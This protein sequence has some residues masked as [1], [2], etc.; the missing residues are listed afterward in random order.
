MHEFAE[1][2]L[3][4]EADALFGELK[5]VDPL[6]AQKYDD[7]NPR[8]VDRAL[9]FYKL[10]GYPISMAQVHHTIAQR[11]D[12]LLF[13]IEQ[14]P[15]VN[16]RAICDRV[17]TMW[18]AGLEGEVRQLLASGV[19]QGSQSMATVGY[20]EMIQYLNG[21]VSERDAK[22]LMIISTRQY[23]KRQRT[24]GRHQFANAVR[25]MG[26]IAD[27]KDSILRTYSSIRG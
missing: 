1:R 10:Y 3:R 2:R 18:D 25:L 22:E 7:R 9:L 21:D 4:G 12:I 14:N 20:R 13:V 6:S 8:R 16:A 27:M 17:N 11:D 26:T 5:E 24:W 19:H 15:D 23:A